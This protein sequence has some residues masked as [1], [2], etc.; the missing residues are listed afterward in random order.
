MLEQAIGRQVNCFLDRCSGNLRPAFSQ[1]RQRISLGQVAQ[2]R[3][4]GNAGASKGQLAMTNA[5]IDDEVLSDDCWLAVPGFAFP[6]G[7]RLRPHMPR[8]LF[9]G[10]YHLQNGDS[11]AI[12]KSFN[13]SAK[14]HERWNDEQLILH[15]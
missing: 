3:F 7:S 13:L 6:L 12:H 15:A 4:H 9:V 2:D 8:L 14:K 1:V 5:G 10:F 11:K